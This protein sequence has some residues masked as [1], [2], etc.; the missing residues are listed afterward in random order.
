[1]LAKDN[2]KTI[3]CTVRRI[4]SPPTRDITGVSVTQTSAVS[5]PAGPFANASSATRSG[6]TED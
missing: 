1:M 4:S 6:V 2:T 5:V 3:D